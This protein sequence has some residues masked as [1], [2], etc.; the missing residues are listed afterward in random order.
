MIN[1]IPES[2]TTHQKCPAAEAGSHCEMVALFSTCH[3]LMASKITTLPENSN[4]AK[5][6][7]WVFTPKLSDVNR[8]HVS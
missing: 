7:F 6:F 2:F 8:R 3:P 5:A 1:P 4:P